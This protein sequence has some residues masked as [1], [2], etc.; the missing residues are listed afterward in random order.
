MTP[1][2]SHNPSTGPIDLNPIYGFSD[3]AFASMHNWHSISRYVFLANEGT[4]T[5]GLKKQATIALSSM[6]AEY[7]ALSEA[8]CEATWLRHLYGELGF[9]Q[10]E[11]ILILGDNDGSI[12]MARNPQFH[13]R[14]KHVDIHR[15]DC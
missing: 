5:W 7:I 9:I 4:I 11:P 12:T 1:S 10:K 13:K 8:G 3:A 6:E 14:T 15:S 2:V